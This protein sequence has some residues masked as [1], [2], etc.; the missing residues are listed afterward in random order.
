MKKPDPFDAD[1]RVTF[2]AELF[3]ITLAFGITAPVE[4]VTVPLIVAPAYWPKAGRFRSKRAAISSPT[5]RDEPPNSRFSGAEVPGLAD[6]F[7]R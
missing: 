5:T 7:I 2:V 1:S 6:L 4:S 3:T